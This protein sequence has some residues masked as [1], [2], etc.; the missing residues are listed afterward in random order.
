MAFAP[1][2]IAAVKGLKRRIQGRR[3]RIKVGNACVNFHPHNRI[4]AAI[5]APW[6]LAA[7]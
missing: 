3:K 6:R 2:E 5:Q 7:M 1:D 4:V